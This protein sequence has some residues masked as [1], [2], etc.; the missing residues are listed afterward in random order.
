MTSEAK[1]MRDRVLIHTRQCV[2]GG[3]DEPVGMVAGISSCCELRD[4]GV[5]GAGCG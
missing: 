4:F 5:S 3:G 2:S 1:E